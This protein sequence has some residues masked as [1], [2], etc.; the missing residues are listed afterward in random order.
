[1]PFLIWSPSVVRMKIGHS[2]S[3]LQC[4]SGTPY[5]VDLVLCGGDLIFSRFDG[6]DEDI[7]RVPIMSHCNTVFCGGT[8]CLGT[9][10]TEIQEV[11][12]S[13][14]A[15]READTSHVQTWCLSHRST[16]AQSCCAIL[17]QLR[18]HP[19]LPT[20]YFA[21]ICIFNLTLRD[22]KSKVILFV[23]NSRYG[24]PLA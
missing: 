9:R 16:G 11:S 2:K 22:A 10:W 18:A 3:L 13:Q 12:E 1:M 8:P 15:G 19:R 21:S 14:I 4:H 6:K 24:R 23:Q 5:F 20:L 7:K 17:W